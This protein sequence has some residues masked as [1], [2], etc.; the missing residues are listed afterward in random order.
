MC[1]K[2]TKDT[3]NK[4]PWSRYKR[5]SYDFKRSGQAK[6]WQLCND[7]CATTGKTYRNWKDNFWVAS[8]VSNVAV[9]WDALLCCAGLAHSQGDPQN[10]VGTKLSCDIWVMTFNYSSMFCNTLVYSNKTRALQI[11]TTFKNCVRERGKIKK[12]T[13]VFCAIH[14]EHQLVNLLLLQDGHALR[15]KQ[16]HVTFVS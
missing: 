14:V 1:S 12:L 11:V 8:E 13:L 5:N 4:N 15:S 6:E 16:T 7:F 2:Q 10:G 9:Q 3:Q